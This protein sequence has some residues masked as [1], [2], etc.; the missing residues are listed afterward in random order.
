MCSKKTLLPQEVS[1]VE[2]PLQR[3]L[4]TVYLGMPCKRQVAEVWCSYTQHSR[5]P[6]IQRSACCWGWEIN[7]ALCTALLL[8]WLFW[9]HHQTFCCSIFLSVPFKEKGSG[10]CR[11]I[12]P[13][14]TGAGAG[15]WKYMWMR[16]GGRIVGDKPDKQKGILVGIK[17]PLIAHKNWRIVER[18]Q[19]VLYKKQSTNL[20]SQIQ[21]ILII[22][23]SY[24]V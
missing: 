10:S 21:L 17:I 4:N 24:V 22:W 2:S 6:A 3:C 23:D 20:Q 16:R 18:C 7:G 12:A 13:K 14:W 19:E 11:C 1:G 5:W 15:E 9:P 8:V